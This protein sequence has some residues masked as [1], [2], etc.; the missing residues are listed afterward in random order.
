MK[1]NRRPLWLILAFF[2]FWGASS[3]FAKGSSHPK[4]S[5]GGGSVMSFDEAP[6]T[7]H[8]WDTRNAVSR[9]GYILVCP[10]EF[11]ADYNWNC[12]EKKSGENRWQR[13]E[14]VVPQGFKIV[15][16]EYRFVG[17]GSRILVVY[18]GQPRTATFQQADELNYILK[19]GTLTINADKVIVQRKRAPQKP[20]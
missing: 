11:S 10:E 16:Y 14:W 7:L 12:T 1:T 19:P 2:M 5:E 9:E 20:R 6:R 15:G 18:L 17:S 4:A 13:L 8:F 3:V